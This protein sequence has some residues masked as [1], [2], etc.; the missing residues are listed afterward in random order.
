MSVNHQSINNVHL[1]PSN[2]LFLFETKNPNDRMFDLSLWF[3][4]H[5]FITCF[6]FGII[7]SWQLFARKKMF[8]SEDNWYRFIFED[9]CKRLVHFKIRQARDWTF[10]GKMRSNAVT[11]D[12]FKAEKTPKTLMMGYFPIL[13]VLKTK[14][15]STNRYI[16]SFI[17]RFVCLHKTCHYIAF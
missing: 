16:N 11:R 4:T 8:F 17:S 6:L 15:Y 3:C 1:I 9:G 7:W 5:I 14:K 12:V 2:S 10:L 13:K